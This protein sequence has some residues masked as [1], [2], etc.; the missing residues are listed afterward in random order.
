MFVIPYF[1]NK[2]YVIHCLSLDQG[3]NCLNIV[4]HTQWGE[5]KIDVCNLVNKSCEVESTNICDWNMFEYWGFCWGIN[6]KYSILVSISPV[7]QTFIC[8]IILNG[9]V[10]EK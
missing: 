7:Q 3:G 9:Q 4:Y 5:E 8:E 10:Q 6:K 2:W 1:V